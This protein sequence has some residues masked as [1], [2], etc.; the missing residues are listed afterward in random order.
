ML[1]ED[2]DEVVVIA[3]MVTRE[4]VRRRGL[5]LVEQLLRASMTRTFE[6]EVDLVRSRGTRV[7]TLTPG[8]DDLD[9]MGPRLLDARRRY[10]VLESS[11]R[12]CRR[13]VRRALDTSARYAFG[14]RSSEE[15]RLA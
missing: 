3:P 15:R 4:P 1:T 5:G 6:R 2:L 7:V 14:P 12:T 10:A 11:L 13:A 8:A 9:V